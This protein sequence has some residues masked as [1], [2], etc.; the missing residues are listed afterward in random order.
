MHMP[1]IVPALLIGDIIS[2]LAVT[3]GGYFWPAVNYPGAW[4]ACLDGTVAIASSAAPLSFLPYSYTCAQNGVAEDITLLA[5]IISFALY[6]LVWSGL[7]VIQMIVHRAKT[8]TSPPVR[9]I[10]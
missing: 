4:L 6:T 1:N 5:V 7:C 8:P 2:I 10:D 9:W 3:L